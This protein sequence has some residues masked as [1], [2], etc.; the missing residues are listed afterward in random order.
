LE[1]LNKIIRLLKEKGVKQK[2]LTDFL[3]VSH[4]VFTEWKAGRNASYMKHLPKIAEFFEVSVD[5]LLGK[6]THTP[7]YN[8]TYALYNELAHDLSEEQIQQLKQFADF[9]RNSNK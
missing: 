3:S 1:V 2:E 9:L 5:Y 6:E 8:F 4:N 7:E